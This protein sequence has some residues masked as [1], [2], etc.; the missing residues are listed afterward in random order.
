MPNEENRGLCEELRRGIV[1]RKL[2][3]TLA[4]DMVTL[5]TEEYN[6]LRDK[7]VLTPVCCGIAILEDDYHAPRYYDPACGIVFDR[8]AEAL[9]CEA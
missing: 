8:E 4:K 6:A 2:L 3:R 7:G 5:Y 9:F 1:N